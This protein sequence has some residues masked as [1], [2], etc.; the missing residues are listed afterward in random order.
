[1]SWSLKGDNLLGMTIYR[2]LI[3]VRGRGGI[4]H[5]PVAL[6]GWPDRKAQQQNQEETLFNVK[7]D[8]VF[9]PE[10]TGMETKERPL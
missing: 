1:M 2:W 3:D 4:V 10:S 7:L 8:N 6:P 5:N 9:Q